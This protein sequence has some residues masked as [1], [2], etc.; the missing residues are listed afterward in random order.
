MAVYPL[1]GVRVLDFTI[2]Q[3][4]PYATVMLADMGADVIKVEEPRGGDPGRGLQPITDAGLGGYFQAH[5]RGKRSVALNLKHP[6][7][8]ETALA[9]ARDADALVHNYRAGVMERLGLGYRDVA[10]VNPDIV[11]VHASGYGPAGDE[12]SEGSFD[13]LAQARGGLMSVTGEPDG[14]PLPAGVPVADQVGA[15][16]AGFAVVSGLLY[17]QRTGRGIEMD[18]SLLGSQL[19]LQAFNITNY[20]FT[21]RV[22]QRRRRAGSTPFWNVYRGSDG[23]YFVIG[24][25]FDRRWPELCAAI[26][27]PELESDP[28]FDTYR[29]RV[30]EG[31]PE[32]IAILD[33]VFATKPAGHWVR[34]LSDAGVFVAPVQDYA[35]VAADPQVLANGYIQEVMDPHRGAVRMVALPVTV[36]GEPL[37]VRGLAPEL[38]AHTEEA[39]LE[40]GYTWQEIA[41]LRAAGA[42]GPARDGPDRPAADS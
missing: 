36:N 25:L 35:D 12:A 32:L 3:Q 20:L 17:R 18:V 38:G 7:G 31:A 22:P 1:E 39:L 30:A 24:M 15:M 26:G 11:Y 40:A 33:D 10:A 21:G 8:R 42:I 34:A 16:M 4:G 6:A 2:W 14:P 23:Q 19:A 41:E 9:L 28:R 5:N 13:I 37:P 29:K 27:R